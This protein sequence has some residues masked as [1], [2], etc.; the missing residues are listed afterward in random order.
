[1]QLKSATTFGG[2]F[3]GFDT[4]TNSN[5]ITTTNDVSSARLLN[6]GEKG[7]INVLDDAQI[8]SSIPV[9]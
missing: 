8:I 1:M 4:I 5:T 3:A 9:K 2:T 6:T 7:A